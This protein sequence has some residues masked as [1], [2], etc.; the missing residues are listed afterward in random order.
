MRTSGWELQI[1][2]Q[3]NIGDF[4][5]SAKLNLSDDRAKVLEYPN[6]ER[7]FGTNNLQAVS[8]C[9]GE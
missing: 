4:I 1:G 2:W 3:D 6:P 9:A 8:Y 7:L 5:Y